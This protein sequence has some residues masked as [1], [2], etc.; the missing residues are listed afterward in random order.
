MGIFSEWTKT[1]WKGR[2]QTRSWEENITEEHQLKMEQQTRK[3]QT[4]RKTRKETEDVKKNGNEEEEEEERNY[5]KKSYVH[6]YRVWTSSLCPRHDV[7][8]NNPA[9]THYI[10]KEQIR[11]HLTT[12]THTHTHT[13]SLSLTHLKGLSICNQR[14]IKQQALGSQCVQSTQQR[15]SVRRWLKVNCVQGAVLQPP[16]P[17]P[18]HLPP[19]LDLRLSQHLQIQANWNWNKTLPDL[20]FLTKYMQNQQVQL[21]KLILCYIAW[22]NNQSKHNV[23]FIHSHHVLHIYIYIYIYLFIYIYIYIYIYRVSQEECARLRESVPYV[24][25]Y[26]Y[27]PK[28]LYPKLNGYRDNALRSLKLWQLL[29]TYW[30]PNTY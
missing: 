18:R 22:H 30:L 28:H 19:R 1:K 3:I 24:K 27:N 4:G 14:N 12:H 17:Y 15:A 6:K 25:V 9:A 8:D 10:I 2:F 11:D 23:Y 16:L 29:H 5:M 26:R 13:L 7:K 20:K 21:A